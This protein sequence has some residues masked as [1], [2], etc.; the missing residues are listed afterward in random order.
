M[1]NE[2]EAFQSL[3]LRFRGR[4]GLTQ[5]HLAERLGVNRRSLQEWENGTTYPCPERLEALLRVLLEVQALSVGQEAAEARTLWAAVQS[6]SPRTHAPFD[7]VWFARLL[8]E[9]SE[10]PPRGGPPVC[11][12]Q[13]AQRI[14][15]WG[16]APDVLG[17]VN[18]T[19]DLALLRSWTVEERCRLVAVLGM[20]GIGKTMFVAKLAQ[21]IAPNFECV[22]WRSLRDALPASDWLAGAL[23]FLYNQQL[24]L[25]SGVAAR[26]TLLLQAL[27]ERR[28]LLVLDNVES[29]LQSGDCDGDPAEGQA[30]YR[31]MLEILGGAAHQSCIVLTSREAPAELL[32]L[33]GG[34]VRTLQLGGLSA[35][36][37]Q[38]VLA[39]KQLVAT[40]QQWSQLTAR[41]G[42]N[43]RALKMIADTIVEL[44]GGDVGA[45][46]EEAGA[47]NVFGGIRKL[48]A[49]QIERSSG[50]EQQLMWVLAVS[51]APMSLRDLRAAVEPHVGCGTLIETLEAL[52]RRSLV[53]SA[54]MDGA[55]VFMLQPA[56]GE[57]VTHLQV[58]MHQRAA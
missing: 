16:D 19:D 42:G 31:Y 36:A 28:C 5:R 54:K 4:C 23:G 50:L 1:S 21:Q 12:V 22:Y 49:E 46:L 33:A 53:E 39:P 8:A 58:G 10:L 35:E 34:R 32:V 2:T 37:V 55:P 9:R 56:V 7:E 24:Q 48:L 41:M 45:F 30:A 43:P 17:F 3:L 52:R 51:P 47:A 57:Y 6:T 38:R 14:E 13:T 18:R 40:S 20:G 27:R 15:D 26:L 11:P 44:F 25:P 29:V